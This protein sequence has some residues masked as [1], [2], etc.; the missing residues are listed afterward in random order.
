MCKHGS[1]KG[2]AGW[3][4]GFHEKIQTYYLKGENK[5]KIPT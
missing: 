5:K 3:V 2:E 1:R 4:E